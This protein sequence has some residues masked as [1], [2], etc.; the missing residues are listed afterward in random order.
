MTSKDHIVNVF[1]KKQ[2]NVVTVPYFSI[3]KISTRVNH[4]KLLLEMCDISLHIITS[5]ILYQ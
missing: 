4:G 2:K 5:M 1:A 3:K